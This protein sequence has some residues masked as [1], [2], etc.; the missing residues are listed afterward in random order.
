MFWIIAAVLVFIALAL[1]LPPLLKPTTELAG[2]GES[3][4][5]LRRLQNIEIAKEQLNELEQRFEKGEMDNDAY[6]QTRDELE[7]ALYNNMQESE[8]DSAFDAAKATSKKS[9]LGSVAIALLVPLIAIGTYLK[10]GDPVFTTDLSSRVAAKTE[11]RKD[12]PKKADGTPDVDAMVSSLQKKME[13][14]PDNAKGWFMLGRSY[15]VMKRYPDAVKAYEQVNRLM[16]N[17]PNVMLSLADAISMENNGQ[18]AGRPAELIEQVLKVDPA[19]VTGL[20]LGGMAARQ[21]LNYVTAVERWQKVLPLL[22]TQKDKNEVNSLIAE[23]MKNM[24]PEQLKA[25]KKQA[26]A[27][28]VAARETAAKGIRVH[29]A[30]S[31]TLKGKANPDD[32]V[33]I[34]AKAVSG[35][36]MPLAVARKRVKDLPVDIVLDDSMAMMPNMKL[37]G[38]SEVI[39]G[40]RVSKSGRPIAQQ[41]DLFTEKKPVKAGQQVDLLINSI[42]GQ[43]APQ[44]SK[45]PVQQQQTQALTASA[46]QAPPLAAAK[47]QKPAMAG[48]GITVTVSL[49]EAMMAQA[50]PDDLVFIY[51]KAVSGPPMP[52]A[53]A[54]KQVKDLP[55]TITLD[56]S[57]AMMPSM[58]LSGFSEVVVGARVSKTGRPIPQNG[59]LFTEKKP[60]KAG[61]SVELI[62]DSVVKR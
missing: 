7:L 21:Q 10:L 45:P 5:Q 13:A 39:I 53:A 42:K 38:F 2:A 29:V 35:P 51:A 4:Q 59:D 54:K 47:A 18:I 27:I 24:S 32:L 8:Q 61:D 16:P 25:V 52:L 58:K 56:D 1:I 11:I 48:Q 34:Y 15:M 33:F 49:S 57:M 14:N 55:V 19:N 9:F 30:L 37:S 62:I 46:Q 60:I 31:D 36:P 40:A 26:E 50:K 43:A 12:L 22:D 20:W 17:S 44:A 28:A 3:S 41:G 6:Q 23:A